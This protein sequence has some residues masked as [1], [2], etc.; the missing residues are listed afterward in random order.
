MSQNNIS[1]TVEV[2]PLNAPIATLIT[3]GGFSVAIIIAI[4]MLLWALTNFTKTLTGANNE[5]VIRMIQEMN[6]KGK[7]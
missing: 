5:L 7:S 6:G 2:S 1:R 3:Y 4:A